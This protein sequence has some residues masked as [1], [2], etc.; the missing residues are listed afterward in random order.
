MS[1]ID[2]PV[3]KHQAQLVEPDHTRI[4]GNTVRVL[5]SAMKQKD[6]NAAS[7]TENANNGI[8]SSPLLNS[9]PPVVVK[10]MVQLYPYLIVA[11]ETLN[12]ISW[13]G[14]NIWSSVL[15]VLW[16]LLAVLYFEVWCKYFGH[17]LIVG[18]FVLYSKLDTF[19]SSVMFDKPSL[20]DMVLIMNRVTFKLDL[21]MS[22]VTN[23]SGEEVKK[24]LTTTIFLS[25]FYIFITFVLLPP[26]KL[27]LIGGIFILTYHSPWCK[28]SRRLLWQFKAVR[29]VTFYVTGLDLRSS[30]NKRQG[31]LANV[32]KKVQMLTN[33]GSLMGTGENG[34]DAGPIR[35]TYVLFENQRR[36]IGVGWT[37]SMLSYERTSWTDEFLN[38]APSPDKFKLPED[39]TNG[40]LKWKWIDRS[41]RLDMSNDSAIQLPSSKPKTLNDPNVDDGYIYYDN[42]WKKPSTADSFGK[43]TRRRRWI[44]TAELLRIAPDDI[45][46]RAKSD[47]TASATAIPTPT[48]ISTGTNTSQTTANTNTTTTTTRRKVSFSAHHNVHLIPTNNSSS[49]IS[50]DEKEPLLNSANSEIELLS[51]RKSK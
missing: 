7:T 1:E 16:Y 47:S 37:S 45:P 48:S 22:P 44:R 32:Q 36:W 4:G 2:V 15:M 38:E 51:H 29:L 3:S 9:T 33:N 8:I 39:D 19:V 21:V 14:E 26:K 40:G 18:G 42:A 31:I 34:E 20:D 10:A 28:V 35:F 25:P 46:N 13:T 23:L 6:K 24:L 27:F 12:L 43:Y 41:W 11:D 50:T 30:I 5:R 49:P 17:M